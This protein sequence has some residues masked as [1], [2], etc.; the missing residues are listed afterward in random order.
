MGFSLGIIC[1]LIQLGMLIGTSKNNKV[2]IIKKSYF[3]NRIYPFRLPQKS[4]LVTDKSVGSLTSILS[5]N[6]HRTDKI[7]ISNWIFQCTVPNGYDPPTCGIITAARRHLAPEP[8]EI[9]W[10][11]GHLSL[12]PRINTL[13]RLKMC[14][15]DV[16]PACV[17][18]HQAIFGLNFLQCS[19]AW[20]ILIKDIA[21]IIGTFFIS[22]HTTRIYTSYSNAYA[23]RIKREKLENLKETQRVLT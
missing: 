23:Q 8:L 21:T 11:V 13:W 7:G 2:S 1:S 14:C 17:Y 15:K 19:K 5:R 22:G 12:G 16:I 18:F 3:W 9:L 4:Q 20:I 6:L 10:E